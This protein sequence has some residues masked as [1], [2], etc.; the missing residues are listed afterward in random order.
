MDPVVGAT[1]LMLKKE[2]ASLYNITG[3]IIFKYRRDLQ[4]NVQTN[5]ILPGNPFT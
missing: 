3:P 4:C 1:D 2:L 5:L